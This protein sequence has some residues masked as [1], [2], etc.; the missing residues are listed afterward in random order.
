LILSTAA[1]EAHYWT[2]YTSYDLNKDGLI[3]KSERTAGFQKAHKG[4]VNDTARN[5]VFFTGIIISMLVSTTVLITGI[6][7]TYFKLR[8]NKVKNYTQQNP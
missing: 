5:L 4:V 8:R 2:D 7:R 1:L 6:I 3:D